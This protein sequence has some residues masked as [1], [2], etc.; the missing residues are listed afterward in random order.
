MTVPDSKIELVRKL[1]AKAESTDSGPEQDALNERASELIARYGI[2][3]AM[4]SDAVA[5][6]VTDISVE[7]PNPYAI[8]WRGLMWGITRPL[9]VRA[10]ATRQ[11]RG[12]TKIITM[13]L[14]GYKTD[15]AYA[16]I[17][18]ASL[19]NQALAGIASIKGDRYWGENTTAE[20][21]SY[22]SG[23][24][25]A[26]E[27]RLENA[28][29]KAEQEQASREQRIRE[30][31]LDAAMLDDDFSLND[32]PSSSPGVALVLANRQDKV[33]AAVAA[34]YPKLGKAAARSLNGGHYGTGHRDG[35]KASLGNSRSLGNAA[36]ALH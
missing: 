1:L 10:V 3:E 8:D 26:V 29:R 31:A 2:E 27:T 23:F 32:T 12:G 28:Q 14:F 25:A 24:S 16:E 36:K 7:L 35:M 34:V 33:E 6:Q 11:W 18:F 9:R 30:A 4:L 15:I 19:R 17:L 21:K 13:R 20:R 22:I 5:D